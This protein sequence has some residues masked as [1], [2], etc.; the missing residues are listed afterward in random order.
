[1]T[2]L[3]WNKYTNIQRS[4]LESVHNN[5]NELDQNPYLNGDDTIQLKTSSQFPPVSLHN[6]SKLSYLTQNNRFLIRVFQDFPVK[7]SSGKT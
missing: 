4:K 5:T 2:E 3:H 6:N 1:M 7:I